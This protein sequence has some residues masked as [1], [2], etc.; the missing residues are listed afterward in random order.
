MQIMTPRKGALW[1]SGFPLRENFH[2]SFGPHLLPQIF[3]GTD[4]QDGQLRKIDF[5]GRY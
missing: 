2:A 4:T 5:S 1:I 3:G